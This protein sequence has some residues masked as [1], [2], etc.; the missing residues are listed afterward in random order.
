MTWCSLIAVN[1][2]LQSEKQI[3]MLLHCFWFWGIVCWCHKWNVSWFLTLYD[4][5]KIY[6]KKLTKFDSFYIFFFFYYSWLSVEHTVHIVSFKNDEI[7]SHDHIISFLVRRCSINC[8][9]LLPATNFFLLSMY[10]PLKTFQQSSW[11]MIQGSKILT[12]QIFA[13]SIAL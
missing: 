8:R 11:Q 6:I 3:K 1:Y 2:K 4:M 10:C 13:V 7:W 9:D 5:K 12:V